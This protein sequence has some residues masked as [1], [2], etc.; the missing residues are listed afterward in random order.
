MDV[1]KIGLAL[2][3][4]LAMGSGTALAQGG[5]G[6]GTGGAAGSGTQQEGGQDQQG[7]A[8]QGSG[9]GAAMGEK[10]QTVSARKYVVKSVDEQAKQVVFVPHDDGSEIEKQSGEELRLSFDELDQHLGM[11]FFGLLGGAEK[12][13]EG[14]SVTIVRG[15]EGIDEVVIDGMT[16]KGDIDLQSGSKD[17]K[18]KKGGKWE[19]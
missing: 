4:A 8:G 17:K 19:Y 10:V 9:A 13:K 12:L 15:T 18:S 5:G 16:D 2:A 6:G 1:K 7:G 3:A 14:H 11:E